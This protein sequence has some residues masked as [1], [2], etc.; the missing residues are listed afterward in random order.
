[1]VGVVLH[2]RSA[3][4]GVL[5]GESGELR[6]VRLPAASDQLLGWLRT[7]PAAVRVA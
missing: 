3:V 4:A 1:L 6:T 5:D 2:A 7:L